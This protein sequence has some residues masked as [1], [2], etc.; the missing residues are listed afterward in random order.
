M[1]KRST[2]RR[3]RR[4]PAVHSPAS[5]QPR[6]RAPLP[7]RSTPALDPG[8][9]GVDES[10]NPLAGWSNLRGIATE[11]GVEYRDLRRNIPRALVRKLGR[12]LYVQRPRFVAWWLQQ[13][14]ESAT[15]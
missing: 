12:T 8:G 6:R 13:P 5:Y 3:R 1:G 15:G 9:G 14:H 10:G 7:A 4:V 11:L 2:K